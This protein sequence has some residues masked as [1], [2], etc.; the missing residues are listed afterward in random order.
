MTCL[1]FNLAVFDYTLDTAADVNSA[2]LR[3]LCSH[4]E[5]LENFTCQGSIPG[6]P[7]DNRQNGTGFWTTCDRAGVEAK[8]TPCTMAFF[9]TPNSFVVQSITVTAYHNGDYA[10]IRVHTSNPNNLDRVFN[11]TNSWGTYVIDSS[12][13]NDI[14][15]LDV[16][17]FWFCFLS[18]F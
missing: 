1:A 17:C 3:V 7:A 10:R 18:L 4:Y 9:R 14:E 2:Y 6:I 5:Q 12:I 11:A 16:S 13:Y 8:V 15:S